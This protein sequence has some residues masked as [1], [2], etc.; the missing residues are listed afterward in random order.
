MHDYSRILSGMRPTGR[1]HIGH[2]HG[3]LKNWIQLQYEHECFFMVADLHALTLNY[4]NTKGIEES[5]YSMVIDWL[6]CGVDPSQAIMFIQSEVPEHAEMFALLS[7]ITPM[8]WLERVPSYKD[9]VEKFT[10]NKELDTYGFL[11]YP[12]LQSADILLYQAKNVPVGDDQVS[13]V[14]LT[15]EI[16]RRFNYIYGREAGFEEKAREAMKK[17]GSKKSELYQELLVSYQQKGDDEALEKARFLLTDAV[18]LS[19]GEKER[20]FAF[21]EN[22]SRVILT[23]PQA[24]ITDTPKIV[25]ID[26]Q[27]M[28]KS[29]NNTIMLRENIDG[30]SKKIRAMPT[31]PARIRRTDCGDP[32]KCPVWQL[33]QV[34]SDESTKKWVQDGCVTAGIGCLECKAPLIDSIEEEQVKFREQAKPYLNDTNLIRNI[35]ADGAE[36][37]GEIAEETLAEVKEVMNLSY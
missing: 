11:G 16:A 17:L 7:M 26:G 19:I 6:A 9:Q 23:E 22:K 24:L 21:L 5:T 4:E 25:G 33:H 15:R 27:K 18:N 12:L 37:A 10:F 14:E 28:S 30:I 1:L 31:D 32:L 34:Y 35:L 2:F 3:A 8:G 29:G 13:H 20:L 36:K